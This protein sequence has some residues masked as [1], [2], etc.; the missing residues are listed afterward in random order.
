MSVPAPTLALMAED[1]EVRVSGRRRKTMAAFR[2]G[3][4]VVV[5]VPEYLSTRDRQRL[6]PD[7]VEK[8]LAKEGRA[9]G[10]RGEQELTARARTLF[11]TYL[12]PAVDGMK[13]AGVAGSPSASGVHPDF[14]VRWV[15]NQK[16]RWGSCSTQTGEIRLSDRLRGMPDWVIDYVL[17]HELTHLVE[18]HHTR[19]FH[20]LVAHYPQATQA[21]GFLQGYV[22]ALRAAGEPEP[23][24]EID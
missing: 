1:Y 3:G 22:H 18:T 12:R 5:V 14:G 7:L 8:F 11:A 6:I 24:G 9:A 2:E 16:S 13:P 17:V 4:R 15:S 23:E 20:E 19:R 10:P 21:K